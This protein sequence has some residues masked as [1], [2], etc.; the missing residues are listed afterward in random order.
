MFPLFFCHSILLFST[1]RPHE[2]IQSQ[3][4]DR[5]HH[6]TNYFHNISLFLIT[7][8][9]W[10]TLCLSTNRLSLTFFLS[11]HQ[12]NSLLYT[13]S[14]FP[15]QPSKFLSDINGKLLINRRTQSLYLFIASDF[16]HQLIQQV[17]PHCVKYWFVHRR[18]PFHD[19]FRICK[20]KRQTA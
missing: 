8:N 11:F 1:K 5:L 18:K 20:F 12:H 3:S 4:A 19:L 9:S 16:L 7:H 10:T 2:F 13:S 6:C 14:S 17:K 15:R